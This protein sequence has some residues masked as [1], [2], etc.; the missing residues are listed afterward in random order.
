M[1]TIGFVAAI[2]G[3]TGTNADLQPLG[4]DTNARCLMSVNLAGLS[5][6]CSQDVYLLHEGFWDAKSRLHSL[7]LS[8]AV[9]KDG[10]LLCMQAKA[11]TDC[12]SKLC[13]HKLAARAFH[14]GCLS[15][16]DLSWI[17]E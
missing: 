6:A 10:V 7:L 15:C 17:I 14:M 16:G 1:Q 13:D 11:D 2:L 9:S 4:A 8:F 5:V 3:K 12:G